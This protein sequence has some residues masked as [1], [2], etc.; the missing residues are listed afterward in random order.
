MSKSLEYED[1][2]DKTANSRLLFEFLLAKGLCGEKSEMA[3]KVTVSFTVNDE[4][5]E[6]PLPSKLSYLQVQ[7]IL[8]ITG[9]TLEEYVKYV[10][11]HI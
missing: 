3:L 10:A 8:Y 6:I 2:T 5:I 4:R 9:T 11:S 1:F 7:H